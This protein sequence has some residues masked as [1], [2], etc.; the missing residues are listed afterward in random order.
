LAKIVE[1][2]FS[3]SAPYSGIQVLLALYAFAFQIFCDFAG[4]SDIARGLGKC[5]GF[6]I[7]INF[8][9]PYFA[10]NPRQFWQRWHISLSS[11]LRDNLY[12]PLGGNRRGSFVTYRNLGITMFL[13]GLWHGAAWT[14]IVWGIYQ[15]VLLI[16]HRMSEPLLKKIPSPKGL[17]TEKI[18][19]LIRVIFFFHLICLGWLIFRAQSMKQVFNMLHGLIFNFSSSGVSLPP[20]ALDLVFLTWLLLLIQAVQFVRNDPL[21]IPKSNLVIKALFFAACLYLIAKKGIPNGEAFIY[22]IF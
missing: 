19:S 12:V 7:M 18:W 11:W 20:V 5:M 14:F 8:N 3:G 2:V 15:G 1:P 16:G 17:I 6:D 13:G 21:F 9:L 10:Q 4:Y 22:Y